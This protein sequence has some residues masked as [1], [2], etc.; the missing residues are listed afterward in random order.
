MKKIG[1]ALGGGGAKGLAHVLMLEAFDELGVRPAAI[2]GSSIGA[3]IAAL[4]ASGLSAQEIRAGIDALVPPLR[5]HLTRRFFRKDLSGLIGRMDPKVG[6][7]GLLRGEKFMAY[8]YRSLSH[9]TFED[10]EIPLTVVAADFWKREQVVFDSG[11][12]L[13]PLKASM[14]LP[15]IF[16]PVL[17]EGRVLI[18]GGTV[19]PVPYDL[20]PADCD[21]TVA[22]DVLGTRAHRAGSR[23]NLLDGIFNTFQIMEKSIVEE[24]LKRKPC[25]IYIR[26]EIVDVRVLEFFRRDLIYRQ[27]APAKEELKRKLAKALD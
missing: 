9:M 25:D 8:L 26:P 22:I 10:L 11:E 21:V 1:L 14:A 4:Y 12:L 6:P 17:H 13:T 20:L 23:P 5:G 3:A 2:A 7:R 15:W 16:R 24:K 18:D 19:N 27:A